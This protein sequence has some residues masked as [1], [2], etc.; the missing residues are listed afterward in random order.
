MTFQEK[1]V[2]VSLASFILI[3]G[4]Y[5]LR[6]L[7]MSQDGSLQEAA[8]F[9]LWGITIVLAIIFTI[10]A[11]ILTHIVSAIIQAIQT[12]EKEPDIE[13]L[14]D[15]RDQLI[16]LRGTKIT[17]SV[18]SLGVFAAMLT[19]VL[20]QPPLTMFTLLIFFGLLAQIIGD[21]ARLVLYRRGF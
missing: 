4:F 19:Y 15:E 16:D 3:L 8:V 7:G 10:I 17:Y 5:L 21:I 9:R 12:G 13:D 1:N 20:G 2:A 14:A 11:T 18:S 6:L